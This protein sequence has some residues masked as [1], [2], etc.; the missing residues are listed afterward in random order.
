MKTEDSNMTNSDDRDRSRE[1]DRIRRSDRPN[2][3]TSNSRDRSRDKSDRNRKIADR[4]IYVSNIP[5]DFRWQDLKDLFRT[6]VGKVAHVELFTD[7]NDKPRGC[8]IVEF[9]DS[10]SVKVAVEKMHRFDIKGRKLVVKEDYDVERDKYGRLTSGRVSDR[11]REE[12]FRDQSRLISG[13]QNIQVSNSVGVGSGASSG[14]SS[15]GTGN[16][17]NKFGNTYG[18]S[19]QFLESLGINGPLVTRIFVANLDYK[20][21]EKKLLEVFKLAG[22]VLH[23]E[24]G[25]DKDGKSRGFGVVEYDH[26]VESVQAISMLHNQQLYDRRMTVRLDRANEPDMPPKLPEGL[27]SIGMGLG[28]GGNRLTDVARNIPNVQPSNLPVANSLT[29]PVIP[30]SAFGTSLSNVVP[31]Q[32]ATALSNTNAAALQASLASGLGAN[33]A[34]TS[35]LN[36]SLSNELASNF[37]P[38]AAS[39]ANLQA[40]LVNAQSNN[41]LLSRGLPKLDTE[42][43]F[44]GNIAFGNST[45]S[46][47]RDFDSSFNRNDPERVTIG[48]T[49]STNPPQLSVNRQNSN[50]SRQISDTILIGNLPPNTTWQMLRD[51]CQDIGEVKYAEMRGNDLGLVRFAS[52][53][54]AERAV[55]LIYKMYP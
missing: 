51:K 11:G 21:D 10:E 6:E 20:V 33:L 41:S 15:A 39:L 4:R 16:V 12:R 55:F 34:T 25:K 18:L 46:S 7:E 54:D 49:F 3:V 17:D 53:W 5:Y 28:A 43:A 45:F 40:S 14:G 8:G 1:R 32:L 30:T 29:T 52:D 27:K 23:V 37:G 24:L 44:G 19:T 35:L 48:G 50:G 13:R 38:S 22:K 2:R 31:A 47:S 9:E 26:P 42:P 36:T